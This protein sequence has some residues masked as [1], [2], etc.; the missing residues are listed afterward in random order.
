MRVL[1]SALVYYRDYKSSLFGANDTNTDADAL[2]INTEAEAIADEFH[3]L[4]STS[5]QG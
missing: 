1:D 3:R 4:M 5:P 2:A